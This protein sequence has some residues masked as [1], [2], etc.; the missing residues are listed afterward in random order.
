M[1]KETLSNNNSGR[2][3][4]NPINRGI[5]YLSI[6]S[7]IVIALLV[8]FLSYTLASSVL[9]KRNK[10]NLSRI[11]AYVEENI[12]VDDLYNCKQTGVA[13]EK[14]QELQLFLNDI[15]DNFNVEYL[16]I[17][18]PT[19]GIMT[20]VISATSK[21]EKAAG[22]GDLGIGE[23]TDAY[24]KEEINRYKSY[25][26]VVGI[27]YFEEDSE[28]GTYFTA[29]KALKNS[30]GQTFALICVDE[31]VASV[32]K[33]IITS[34]IYITLAVILALGVFGLTI[35]TYIRRNVTN[36]LI[37]LE[38]NATDFAKQS[39]DSSN[40]SELHFITNNIKTKNEVESLAKALETMAYN[41]K[42]KISET[43]ESSK[44]AELSESLSTLLNNMPVMTFYKE[45]ET[46]KYIMCNQSFADYCYLEKPEDV[47]GLTDF[48]LFD[49]VTARHFVE[50]DQIALSLDRPYSFFEDAFDPRGNK[51]QFQT[52]K[53]KFVDAQGKTRILGMCMDVTE[54]V[55]AKQESEISKEEYEKEKDISSM[56]SR[57]ASALSQDYVYIYYVNI[58]TDE[59]IE[60]R[61]NIFKDGL[62]IER[63]G[64]D[65][66]NESLKNAP[67]L[68]Y[69]EDLPAFLSVFS[70]ENIIDK[71]D[72]MGTLTL[73]YR[74]MMNDRPNYVSMKITKYG[75]ESRHIII[76]INNID[77]QMKEQEAL[78]RIQEERI[79]Y[80]RITALSG[81][82]ICIYAVNP[83]TGKFLEYGAKK[84][85][86]SLG[87][88]KEGKDFFSLVK[89]EML[90]YIYAD[91]VDLF[92]TCLEKDYLIKN[93]EKNTTFAFNYRLILNK[94]IV[95]VTL[96]AALV[97]EN[98]GKQLIIGIINANEQVKKDRE[99]TSTLSTVKKQANIDALTGVRNKHAYIDM[100]EK[101]NQLIYENSMT[102]FA[103]VIFD[104]NNLKTINDVKGHIA[105]DQYIQNACTIICDIFK[106]SPVYR[107][108][109]DEFASVVEG[110]DYE[111]IETLTERIK[112][113]N[114]ENLKDD[115]VVIACGYAK[116]LDDKNVAEVFNRADNRM[117][118]NKKWLK[119]RLK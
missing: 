94:K 89:Y 10:D 37:E 6:I 49:E 41:L 97:D 40:V 11:I 39:N 22:E 17:V 80:G 117:Y 29:C 74:Q 3:I 51:K 118:E 99:Y 24:S 90:K 119:E 111:N 64:T 67:M 95:F 32:N 48:D 52:T 96:K 114:L 71:I 106:H 86:E 33:T 58:Q 84:D 35:I 23:T 47:K 61:P 69:K 28:Y 4:K 75:K 76:G 1:E 108:G 112:E 113:S 72:K 27:N 62:N 104:I 34:V 92:N 60:Y 50:K 42:A 8:L 18:D 110:R 82:Y 109:G 7:F 46:G 19:P 68:I 101:I 85:Y 12:D 31:E 116:Y 25:W 100:E 44:I 98:D 21:E 30:S 43:I 81:D 53:L 91:D 83:E 65:F 93:I 54:M 2:Y 102:P 55:S 66:F 103:I 70:K 5:L 57:I 16:Y 36:P 26:S 13:S 9:H 115:G 88:A 105:G 15:V 38:K 20:N 59:F 77:A 78:K 63:K 14:Y 45:I 79:T 87:L 56:Y 73:T 107:I